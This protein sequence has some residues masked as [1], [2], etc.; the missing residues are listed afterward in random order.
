LQ[1]L[2]KILF[3]KMHKKY[4]FYSKN[5]FDNNNIIKYDGH[6]LSYK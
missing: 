2:N 1:K 3:K 5:T 4:S 6:S